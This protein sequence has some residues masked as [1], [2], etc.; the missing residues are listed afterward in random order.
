MHDQSIIR[1]EVQAKVVGRRMQVAGSGLKVAASR[2]TALGTI[3]PLAFH[4]APRNFLEAQF[5]QYK[6]CILL[7]AQKRAYGLSALLLCTNKCT[8]TS[9]C[10]VG[11]RNDL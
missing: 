8:H 4:D 1:H 10:F 3:L 9:R 6:L 11:G 7:R 2:T 5:E